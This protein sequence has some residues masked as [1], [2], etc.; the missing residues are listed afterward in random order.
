[1]PAT[2]SALPF[3]S[4]HGLSR[5]KNEPNSGL[6]LLVSMPSPPIAL[7]ASTPSVFARISSICRSTLSVRWSDEPSGSW[8]L[9]MKMP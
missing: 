8:T 9:I 3:R 7:Q 5:Q 2:Y 1:M 4:P 6:K